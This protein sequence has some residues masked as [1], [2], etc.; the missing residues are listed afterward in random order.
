MINGLKMSMLVIIFCLAGCQQE[1]DDLNAYVANIKAQQKSDI[2]PIPVMKPY[3]KFEYAAA[4]LRDPF[5]PT[6][7]DVPEIAAEPEFDNGISPD[8]NRRKEALEAFALSQLQYVGTLEQDKIWALVR[9]PDGV[10]HR[11]QVGNYM[12]QSHGRITSISETGLTLNEIVPK[13]NS[14]FIERETSVSAVEVN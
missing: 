12:G 10:I 1:K 2:P 11:V 9:A 6:V 5:L 8:T 13:G 14:G 3:E 4:D 7:V